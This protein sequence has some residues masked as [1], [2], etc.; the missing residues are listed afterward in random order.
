MPRRRRRYA[1]AGRPRRFGRFRR[2]MAG[3]TIPILP[4]AAVAYVTLL[5]P[6]PWAASNDT[7]L[8]K[9]QHGNFQGFAQDLVTQ[10]VGFTPDMK[11]FDWNIAAGFWGPI[12]GGAVGHMIANKVGINR[13]M[14]RI[15]MVGKYL[16]L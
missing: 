11:N 9:L 14:H 4:V 1:M 13:Y 2:R 16:S 3:K 12:I 15:P 7:P 6:H 10:A 8:F 5:K